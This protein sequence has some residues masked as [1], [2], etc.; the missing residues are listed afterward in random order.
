MWK[1]GALSLITLC[2]MEYDG[3]TRDCA[4]VYEKSEWN[5]ICNTEKTLVAM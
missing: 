2:V 5:I 4:R 3:V 1:Q